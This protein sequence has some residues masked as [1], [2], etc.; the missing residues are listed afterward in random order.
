MY[1]VNV[2]GVR[3]DFFL[4]NEEANR[5]RREFDSM[6]KLPVDSLKFQTEILKY[7]KIMEN[8]FDPNMMI[9]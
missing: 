9:G 2:K 6:L 3:P 5:I 8:D 4:F 1:N 7:E